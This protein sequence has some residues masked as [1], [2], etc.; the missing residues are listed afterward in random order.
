[1][2]HCCC[3]ATLLLGLL[4]VCHPNLALPL[5][6]PDVT[7]TPIQRIDL[8]TFTSISDQT[9][10]IQEHIALRRPVVFTNHA[11]LQ[12]HWPAFSKWT[13]PH[14]LS[15]A[16]DH[17]P[18]PVKVSTSPVFTLYALDAKRGHH[19]SALQGG[20]EKDQRRYRFQNVTIEDTLYPEQ[21]TS[22]DAHT[23]H[24]YRYY[25]G[26]LPSGLATDVQLADLIVPEVSAS[27]S[28]GIV[29]MGNQGVTA[30]LHYDRS[31][32]MF[33]QVV[34]QKSFYLFPPTASFSLFPS[35]SGSRRQCRYQFPL[36]DSATCDGDHPRSAARS[37]TDDGPAPTATLATLQPGDLLYVPP[38]YYHTVVS[39]S[40]QTISYSVLSPSLE[41]YYYSSALYAKVNFVALGQPGSRRLRLGVVLY[42]NRILKSLALPFDIFMASLYE[43]RHAVS[44]GETGE[45]EE[46]VV[47]DKSQCQCK[48]KIERFKIEKL[49]GKGPLKEAVKNVTEAFEKIRVVGGEGPFRI[50]LQ[51]YIEEL[52]VFVTVEKE[53]GEVGSAGT[54][55]K[56]VEV[57]GKE[58]KS[59]ER[60]QT[61]N[62]VAQVIRRCWKTTPD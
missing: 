59:G 11:N 29:W 23:D 8:S 52:L 58:Q 38:F 42:I 28:R 15:T 36:L 43:T 10:H 45:A 17:L 25:A 30:Q 37:S 51:D 2:T 44:A 40:P 55:E 9:K 6:L 56:E 31:F 34:G 49:L 12:H 48:N 57:G 7:T 39:L 27:M 13:S 33:V 47:E 20:L 54:V 19:E 46:E 62:R 26:P 61:L 35:F 50:L 22:N 24:P 53:G 1:M 18:L 14:Y 21:S 5:L 16:F 41:E 60:R 4:L 3:P 32:N